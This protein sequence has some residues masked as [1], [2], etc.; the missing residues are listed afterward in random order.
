[1]LIMVAPHVGA[2]IEIISSCVKWTGNSES[3]P[4]W[5]RGLKYDPGDG[6]EIPLESLPMWERG[7][8]C[9]AIEYLRNGT[10]V[11]PHVGAWIEIPIK[12]DE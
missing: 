2:W 1:M 4:M 7:L 5:E 6:S 3:L 12:P 10:V 8:K 11:A 9:N